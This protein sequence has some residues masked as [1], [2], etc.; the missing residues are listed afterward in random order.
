MK[1]NETG[2]VFIRG[3]WKY[4][5]SSISRKLQGCDCEAKH[6]LLSGAL[7]LAYIK[8]FCLALL[9]KYESSLAL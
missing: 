8:D 7:A 3:T 6:L 2:K 5:L 9:L 1:E 4:V